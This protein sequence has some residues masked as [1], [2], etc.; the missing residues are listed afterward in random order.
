MRW[1]G[2]LT[3][4]VGGGIEGLIGTGGWRWKAEFL[5]IDLGSVGGASIGGLT[6]N[7]GR[8]TDEIIRVG[9]NYRFGAP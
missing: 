4:R 7:G 8:F 9:L 3:P 1:Q 2:R 5:H 6:I